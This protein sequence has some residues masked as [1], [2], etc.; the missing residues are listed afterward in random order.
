LHA[1]KARTAGSHRLDRL[2][3]R[4]NAALLVIIKVLTCER[5]GSTLY[6]SVTSAPFNP[7]EAIAVGISE[8]FSALLRPLDCPLS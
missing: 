4:E 6:C 5:Y 1:I 2:A 8:P 3:R 7:R